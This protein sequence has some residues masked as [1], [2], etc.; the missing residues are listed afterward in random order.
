MAGPHEPWKP[1]Q[2]GQP[3]YHPNYDRCAIITTTVAPLF[4]TTIPPSRKGGVS[5]IITGVTPPCTKYVTV[6]KTGSVP[7]FTTLQPASTGGDTTVSR[8]VNS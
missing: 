2:P 3:D 7:Y 6:T 8:S 5:T 4:C 1:G